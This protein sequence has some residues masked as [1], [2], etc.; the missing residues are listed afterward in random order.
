M[1]LRLVAALAATI[2]FSALTGLRPALVALAAMLMLFP[3]S[4]SMVPWR[5]LLHLEAFL[6]LLL[7]TLPFTIPG[8]PLLTFGPLTA[9]AEG[10]HRAV[11]LAAKVT[12]SVLALTFLVGTAEPQR[13]GQ[14][15]RG[16]GLPDTFVRIFVTTARYLSL[17]RDEFQRLQGAMR[18]RAFVPR[19]NRHSWRS[20]GW[21]FGM[22]L[23]RA[24]NRADRIEE[25]MRLRGFSGRWPM[26]VQPCPTRRDWT[27]LLLWA[28]AA[29]LLLTWDRLR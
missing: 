22:L 15:M 10:M 16:L 6:A 19:S 1:R 24:M 7:L 28:G 11:L 9:S 13:L 26:P 5:R 18:A 12:A 17:I 21:L 25:A 3:L 27:A 2:A 14:A 20:H 23:L 29:T 4:G 8:Q